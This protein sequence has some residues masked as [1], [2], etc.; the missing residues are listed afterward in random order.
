MLKCIRASNHLEIHNKSS[1]FLTLTCALAFT[2]QFSAGLVIL[3]PLATAGTCGTR[4]RCYLCIFITFRICSRW[5]GLNVALLLP[6]SRYHTGR[7]RCG[8]SVCTVRRFLNCQSSRMT[9]SKEIN[10]VYLEF[11]LSNT[12]HLLSFNVFRLLWRNVNRWTVRH[13][14]YDWRVWWFVDISIFH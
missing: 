13:G 1:A 4:Y 12:V 2:G 9:V 11:M 3:G 5:L 10:A 8:I 6:F 14:R 7:I